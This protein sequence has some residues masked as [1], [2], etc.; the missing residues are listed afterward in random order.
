MR[1]S[2]YAYLLGALLAVSCADSGTVMVDAEWNLTCPVGGAFGCGSL[3]QETCLGT[4]GNRAIIGAR[5]DMSCTGDPI[6]VSCEAV[7]RTDGRTVFFLKA[8]IGD[9]FAL[10]LA[11][12]SIDAG[13]GSAEASGCFVRILESQA[14]Y[15]GLATGQCGTD[16]PSLEQPCQLSNIATG[17]GEVV[18]DLECRSLRSSTTGNAFDVGA[19][20]GGPTTIRFANCT[21]F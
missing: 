7:H 17:D 8:N 4:V 3:A 6:V 5:G 13:D 18:F 11:G 14:E 16:A 19:L 1:I 12:A 9:D 2:R 20:G 21:G 10:E 15:G